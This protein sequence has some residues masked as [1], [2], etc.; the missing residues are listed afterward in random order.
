MCFW[1]ASLQIEK[2]N[3]RRRHTRFRMR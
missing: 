3:C 1:R 2:Y